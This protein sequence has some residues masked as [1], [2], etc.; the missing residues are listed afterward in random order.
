MDGHGPTSSASQ[1]AHVAHAAT[2]STP[3]AMGHI[4][5]VRRSSSGTSSRSK[6]LYSTRCPWFKDADADQP[7]SHTTTASRVTQRVLTS[8]VVQG[9]TEEP[10]RK[11]QL[12]ALDVKTASLQ[13]VTYE[14]LAEHT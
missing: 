2:S 9:Q 4:M 1:Y 6:I 7:R 14:E 8:L 11:W 12:R 3:D 5:E 10:A 13:G